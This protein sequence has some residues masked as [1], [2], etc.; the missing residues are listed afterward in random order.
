M[1]NLDNNIKKIHLIGIGGIGVSALAEILHSKGYDITGSDIK[2]SDITRNL[3]KKGISI[4]YNHIGDNVKNVDLVVY[5]S[6]V[7]DENPEIQTAK[8]L[9]IPLL[10]RAEMLGQIIGMYENGV[11]ISGAHGKTTTTSML[12]AI[13]NNTEEDA[14]LLVGGKLDEIGGNVK[15]GHGKTIVTE[16]CEYKE[17]FLHFNPNMAVVLNIDEDHLDYYENLEHIISAFTAFIKTVP[18]KGT[19]IINADDFHAKKLISHVE[20]RLITFGITMETTYQARNITFS[21]DGMPK[22][23]VYYED[24]LLLKC[25]LKIPGQ[26]NIY[27]ALASIASAHQLGVPVDLIQGAFKSFHGAHRRYDILGRFNEGLVVDDYAHHPAEIKAT[28]TASLK[29]PHDRTIVVFQPHTYTRTQ[30]LLLEFSTSFKDADIVIVTDIYAARE[31]DNGEIHSKDLVALLVEEGVNAK[32]NESFEDILNWL[33][34]EVQPG[35]LVF[36][37]GA[38]NVNEIGYD[39]IK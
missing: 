26:H 7:S 14:T 32:Y 24:K 6:A 23:E 19:V 37:M 36:T 25:Q 9:N 5:T 1:I 18:K 33:R 8:A 22:F 30:E 35:D 29:I 21:E 4:A 10:S 2:E 38:G 11:A 39:L 28:L 17:N 13:L 34:T 3:M 20:S 27:N 31:K 16:A 15:V 12:A